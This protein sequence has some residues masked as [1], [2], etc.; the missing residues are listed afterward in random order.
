MICRDCGDDFDKKTVKA[1]FINQCDACSRKSGDLDIK[2]LGRQGSSNKSASIEVMRYD[3]E[4]ARRMIK[5]E[6]RRGRNPSL[7]LSTPKYEKT[8]EGIREE[9]D[10]GGD[11]EEVDFDYLN[12]NK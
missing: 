9:E 11:K 3:L 8:K 2:Y 4:N 1:G 12:Q 10:R 6:N 7:N 5:F